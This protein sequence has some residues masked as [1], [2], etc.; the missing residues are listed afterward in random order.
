MIDVIDRTRCWAASAM[1]CTI[2]PPMDMPAT[3][4]DS[5]PR[6]SRRPKPSAAMSSREYGARTGSPVKARTSVPRVTL[7]GTRLDLPASRLS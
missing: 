4:A 3:C 7:P 6:W 1:V 2:I 5:M